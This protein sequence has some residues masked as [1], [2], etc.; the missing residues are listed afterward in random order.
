MRLTI[1]HL[2]NECLKIG[3]Y[4]WN[5]SLVTPLHKKGSIQD[6]NNYRAIAVASNLEKLF[7]MILF[8]KLVNYRAVY[9]PDTPNQL[10]F[11]KGAQTSDHNITFLP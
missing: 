4:P 1:C 5:T 9:Q 2:L 7:S 11:C 10:G 3:A 6:P 8:Q